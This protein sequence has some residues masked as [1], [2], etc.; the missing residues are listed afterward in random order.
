MRIKIFHDF[1]SKIFQI[2]LFEKQIK[3]I[4][5]SDKQSLYDILC[6]VNLVLRF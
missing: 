2:K 1:N 6:F 3:N 5:Y 4:I